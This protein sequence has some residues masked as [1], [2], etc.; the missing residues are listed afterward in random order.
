MLYLIKNEWDKVFYQKNNYIMMILIVLLTAALNFI[1]LLLG[2]NIKENNQYSDNWEQELK[3]QI[4]DIKADNMDTLG[5]DAVL[6]DL[7]ATANQDQIDRLNYH[8]EQGII[9]PSDTNFY[10]ALVRTSNLT[11]LVGAFVAIIASGIMSKEFSMKTI[12]LLLI[13]SRSRTSVFISKYFFL[14]LLV[15]FYYFLLYVSTASFALLFT[16]MNPTSDY[17]FM[18]SD[19]LYTHLH[20][21]YY[22]VSLSVSNILYLIIIAT[23]GFVVSTISRNT[24]IASVTTLGSIFLGPGFTAYLFTKTNLARYL[25]MANWNIKQYFLD[26]TTTLNNGISLP[27]SIVIISIYMISG[28]SLSYY[29]FTKRD[30]LI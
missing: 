3:A 28:I 8:L 14:L 29:L 16:N 30:I 26:R 7:I 1:P 27:F 11:V 5:N 21:G 12:K 9:P 25:L 24:T 20:F 22:F 4:H 10:S 13:H 2:E 23:I 15:I 6:N 19:G 17:V 18:G